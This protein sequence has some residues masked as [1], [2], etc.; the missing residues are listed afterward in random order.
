[1]VYNAIMQFL[2]TCRGIPASLFVGFLC[3][4]CAPL[5]SQEIESSTSPEV[6]EI[7]GKRKSP[8]GEVG[9]AIDGALQWLAQH[10]EDAG[11]WDADN[12][13]KRAPIESEPLTNGTGKHDVDLGISG[14]A[15]L[16]FLSNGHHPESDKYAQAIRR[17][18]EWIAQQQQDSGLFSNSRF[19]HHTIYCHAIATL[20]LA[21][22]RLVS[23]SRQYDQAIEKAVQVILKARNPYA[24][25]RY[26]LKPDGESDSSVTGW[27]VSA[28]K[29]AQAGGTTIPQVAFDGAEYWF[30]EITDPGTG[31]TGYYDTNRGQGGP[32]S[33]RRDQLEMFP[34]KYSESL[35]ALSLLCRIWMT[36][37]NK[38]KSKRQHPHK[39]LF[40][41]QANLIMRI[42]PDWKKIQTVDMYYW[43]YASL[44]MAQHRGD[45]W[46]TWKKKLLNTLVDH[47][48]K[49]GNF[50]GSW[51]PIGA[52]GTDGGRVYSTALGVLIVN[53]E[54]RYKWWY[55]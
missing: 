37:W 52:W 35:T 13:M 2:R 9:R 10:Q 29:T 24:A 11:H 30:S 28:L 47:Q 12:F 15:V 4:S 6:I 53:A 19:G 50:N 32:P 38:V 25:W 34:V 41:K 1:M 31:R 14:L 5:W 21:E 40:A 55:R 36:D 7:L 22:A 18:L 20:A 45:G 54:T 33:R 17:A 43:Y 46:K 44:A 26:N 3:C 49:D 39:E 16:A 42:E 27:V 48:R 8:R 23:G 51:D